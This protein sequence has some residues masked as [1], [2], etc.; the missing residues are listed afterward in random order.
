MGFLFAVTRSPFEP[1][2]PLLPAQP[3]G[4]SGRVKL[5]WPPTDEPIDDEQSVCQDEKKKKEKS[6]PGG[7]GNF[8]SVSDASYAAEGRFFRRGSFA[9]ERERVPLGF[10]GKY[11]FVGGETF[12]PGK[13]PSSAK[14]S[15]CGITRVAHR[16]QKITPPS[17]KSAKE[18]N[19]R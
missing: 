8:C 3:A 7:G 2:H 12:S 17:Y 4:N 9:G 6:S 18:A 5:G 11:G 19:I 1:Q 13:T 14:P 16:T 15:L 10:V